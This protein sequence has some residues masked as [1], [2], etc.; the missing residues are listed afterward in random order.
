MSV[1]IQC[2]SATRASHLTFHFI[3]KNLKK[4]LGINMP[5]I[6][7]K[8]FNS[9]NRFIWI[10]R[11]KDSP[12]MP[13]RQGKPAIHTSLTLIMQGMLLRKGHT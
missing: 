10:C 3:E 12:S 1:V 4:R 2:I 6:D 9:N 8:V 5:L 7:E 13:E 11:R